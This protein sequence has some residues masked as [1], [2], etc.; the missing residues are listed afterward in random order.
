MRKVFANGV[1]FHY[2]QHG[3]GSDVVLVH[4]V[5]ANLSYWLLTVV[6]TLME[7]YRVTIYDLR[8]HGYSDMPPTDYTSG[9]MAEDLEGLMEALGIEQAHIV[10]HSFGSAIVLHHALRYPERVRSLVIADPYIPVLRP[11]VSFK[12]WPLYPELQ[13]VADEFGV[14]LPDDP[15]GWDVPSVVA[16]LPKMP[17]WYGVR[18]GLPRL[19]TRLRRMTERTT[20]MDDMHDVSDLTEERIP[21][22][23]VPTLAL[24][25]ELSPF[26]AMCRYLEQHLPNCR[27]LI[28][29]GGDHFFPAVAPEELAAQ[30]AAYCDSVEAGAVA[31][32]SVS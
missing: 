32:A 31:G 22:V 21:T 25:S 16:E 15:D 12:D 2:Q 26:V 13:R 24:Y 1:N 14:K 29:P 9:A 30:I 17:T 10:G 8:G 23:T 5:T 4:G 20:W 19:D 7:H 6:P 28:V 3:R 27:S 11:Y 18:R